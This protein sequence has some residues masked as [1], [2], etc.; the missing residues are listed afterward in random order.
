MSSDHIPQDLNSWLAYIEVL[1]PKSIAMGL[2]RLNEVK[3]RLGL[4]PSFPLIV[5]A[6]TNGKG[7]CCAMLERIYLEAG[8]KVACYTS[9]HLLRFNERVRVNCSEVSDADLCLAFA[10]VEQA[11]Q[12]TSLTYFEYATLAA[13]WH[14]QQARVD[15]AI[16]EVGLG[17]RLDAVNAFE[18][19]ATMV[20][21]IDLDHMD[22]LGHSR[23]SI[24]YEK[25]GVFRPQV[26]AVCGERNPPLSLLMRASNIAADLHCLQRDFSYTAT[27]QSWSYFEFGI[28][29]FEHLPLPALTGE[30]QLDNAASV[31]RLVQGLKNILPVT[32]DNIAQGLRNVT[33]LGRFQTIVQQPQVIVDVAHNP[34]AAK[35]LVHNL[36]QKPVTGK[37]LAVFAM[38]ADKDIAGVVQALST[39]VDTWYLAGIEHARGASVQQ[40]QNQ[41]EMHAHKTTAQIKIYQDVLSAYCQACLDADEN[42][43]IVVLGSFFTV[44]DVLRQVGRA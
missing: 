37:T 9:P 26:L 15:V 31:I 32:A 24:G 18:P 20:T 19:S 2:E 42:D 29:I 7:S 36:A 22:F 27:G 21:T 39:E 25:S 4:Q 28:A 35:S 11:R 14:F 38:L 10:A 1:H 33:L 17:G 40:L 3:L 12:E 30:F 6:G 5:V 41:V 44:A 13:V 8:Y 23:E 43:R 34:H 16:L